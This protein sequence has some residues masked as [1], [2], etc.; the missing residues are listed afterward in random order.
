MLSGEYAI[1]SSA[2]YQ[3]FCSNFMAGQA[4][5]FKPC[6]A[7]HRRG[8]HGRRQ[9]GRR[10]RVAEQRERGAGRPRVAYD[11]DTGEYRSIYGL[12]RMNHENTVAIP[13]YGHPVLLT[14]DDTF[15]A[16]SSQLY[17]YLADS[18]DAVWNDEGH[19]WAF[20]SDVPAVND[21]GDLGH[22]PSVSGEFIPVP[23]AI[24]DGG[25]TGLENWSND[26]NVFQFIRL[27]DIAYDR[28]RRTSSTWPTP[29]SRASRSGTRRPGG[30]CAGAERDAGPY[31]NG[32]VFKLVLD[33]EDDTRRAQPLDP[34]QRRCGRLL[35]R[36][37][38][39][40]PD[41]LETTKNSLLV[42]EDPGSHKQRDERELPER[43]QC[44]SL[45][46]RPRYRVICAG[47]RGEPD[48]RSRGKEGALGVLRDRG[49]L[50]GVRGGSVP[51]HGAGTLLDRDAAGSVRRFHR[52]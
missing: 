40:Q 25:Q 26:N 35:Q 27:E 22:V 51:C 2:G 45:A 34:D 16:P 21:Y 1:P 7:L 52:D 9:P 28:N 49:R 15:S 33:P 11:P 3:R 13:G 29:A 42:Q 6:P 18:R 23:D 19:L 14:D 37:V 4:E 39:H 48:A 12:G 8:G 5:G 43:D 46:P 10:A 36:A 24:A 20:R 44:A 31:M 50:Q 30:S 17:M 47:R 32:R 38:L 41:N